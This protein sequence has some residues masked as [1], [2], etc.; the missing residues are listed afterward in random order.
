MYLGV[1][2]SKDNYFTIHASS[3]G[4]KYAAAIVNVIHNYFGSKQL[5]DH[6]VMILGDFNRH[7][8]DLENALK[9]YL[10]LYRIF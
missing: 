6:E 7:P 10:L 8:S 5:Y 3:S 4:G 9:R 2:L 1:Q